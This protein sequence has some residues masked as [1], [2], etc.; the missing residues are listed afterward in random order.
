M[1]GMDFGTTNSGA[2]LFDGADVHLLPLDPASR[3]PH[4]CRTAIYITRG[5]EYYL[6]SRG[7]NLY[8][9]QNV[10]RPTQYRKVRVG[11]IVQI[12][13][14][15]PTFYR[16][17]YV[18]EDEF[19]PGRLFL[20]IKTVLRNPTFHGTAFQNRW[21]SA[22]DLTALF[23]MGMKIQMERHL[24][25]E[26]ARIVLGR[27]VHFST[28]PAEDRIAQGRLLQ[29]AFKA[30][31]KQVWL[32]Y[33]PVAA[34]L[35]Y[36]RTLT[37]PETVLVF[38]FG[39]GTLDFTVMEVGGKE[40]RVLASG[41]L[42]VAGD[43]F[44]QRL[45][46]AA[47]PRHLG[48]GG[49]F[50]SGGSRYPIPA[51]IYDLLTTPQE[52]VG[53]NTPQNLEMLRS[54][55]AG[56][57]DKPKTEALLQIVS[58]NYALYLFDRVERAKRLLSHQADA[59]ISLSGRG[60]IIEE[61]VTRGRFEAAILRDYLAIHAEL[62]ATLERA[63]LAPAQVD[64]VIRTGGSSQIPLFVGLLEQIFGAEKVRGIDVFSSV[65]S[66]LAIRG[67]EIEHGLAEST[68]YTPESTQK[69]SETARM[70]VDGEEEEPPAV[71]VDLDEARQRL[72][73]AQDFFAGEARMP[74]TGILALENGFLRLFP[75]F[76]RTDLSPGKRLEEDRLEGVQ[77]ALLARPADH[78][79]MITN[80]YKLIS[81]PFQALVLAQQSVSHGID[82]LL[83]LES[84]ESLSAVTIWQPESLARRFLCLVTNTG[85]A[86]TFDARLL[87]EHIAL[88]PYFQLE[89][90]Y[91]GLPAGLILANEGDLLL[92]GTS[93]G[94]VARAWARDLQVMVTD[95][96]KAKRDEVVSTIACGLQEQE[97]W[98][99][100][101][102]QA[103]ALPFRPVEINGAA[104]RR[105]SARLVGLFPVEG[106][107]LL[108]LTSNGRLLALPLT[109]AMAPGR[110]LARL[111]PEE[112][113]IS[114]WNQP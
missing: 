8:F 14:E 20:S 106:G 23:L 54:I 37:R 53:L 110:K 55:H 28:D 48:E 114:C 31:F 108:G 12:F 84:G 91:V 49:E 113:L 56:S 77:A 74:E 46:R 107:P 68:V 6:G 2:A 60:F 47:L 1:I 26:V 75:L 7:V 30:G 71:E 93:A 65:T 4:I 39:G 88:R 98:A 40:R 3:A 57:L 67:Y 58:S 19:S 13:A 35:S 70:G 81:V 10:G 96:L 64:R 101:T 51:H 44:D 18:Y 15:L 38:D 105:R 59:V 92:A 61:R 83:H 103:V 5:Q 41:G 32:E 17:V 22:S 82:D 27:P 66:G 29:S 99:A 21:Y 104:W 102:Q 34:A 89:R 45:F 16:D 109:P 86:R 87:A 100:V 36:E 79:L 43:V 50:V 72:E 62:E 94:R 9:E 85:Q 76:E 90:R 111:Q 95:L 33:E 11:E 80:T 97:E 24:D 63:G 112:R 69:L 42:P 73:A 25:R 52:V 78:V